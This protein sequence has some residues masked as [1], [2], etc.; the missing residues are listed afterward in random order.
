MSKRTIGEVLK[1]Q[2]DLVDDGNFN[3]GRIWE[4]LTGQRSFDSTTGTKNFGIKRLKLK[5]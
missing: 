4:A 1:F 2:K 5:V 3:E